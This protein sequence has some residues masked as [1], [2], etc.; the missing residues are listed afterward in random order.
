MDLG[1]TQCCPSRMAIVEVEQLRLELLVIEIGETLGMRRDTCRTWQLGWW[2]TG[3]GVQRVIML[4]T[5]GLQDLIDRTAPGAA[6]RMLVRRDAAIRT[7]KPAVV[8]VDR[9]SRDRR[10]G[11]DRTHSDA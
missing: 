8:A 5:G 2:R 1:Q 6:E 10:D 4:Q 3:P 11:R 7:G 9:N